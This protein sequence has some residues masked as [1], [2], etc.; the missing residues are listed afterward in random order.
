MLRLNPLVLS[1][2]LDLLLCLDTAVTERINLSDL[3]LELTD[4]HVFSE[5]ISHLKAATIR[6]LKKRFEL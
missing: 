3:N 5:K 6:Y 1:F 4:P 2:T